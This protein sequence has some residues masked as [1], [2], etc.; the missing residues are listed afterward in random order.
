M[1]ASNTES[2]L[3]AEDSASSKAKKSY[4]LAPLPPVREEVSSKTLKMCD[5]TKQIASNSKNK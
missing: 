4:K 2:S 1:D 3:E 5:Y